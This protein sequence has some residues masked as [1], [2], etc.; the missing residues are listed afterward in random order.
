MGTIAFQVGLG[1]DGQTQFDIF[2]ISQQNIS[3]GDM[4]TKLSSGTILGQF[5]AASLF[6]NSL[7]GLYVPYVHLSFGPTT[8]YKASAGYSM[9]QLTLEVDLATDVPI[10]SGNPFVTLEGLSLEI[11]YGGA[12]DGLPSDISVFGS[13]IVNLG[14]YDADCTFQVDHTGDEIAAFLDDDS[15]DTTGPTSSDSTGGFQGTIMLTID[16]PNETPTVGAMVDGLLGEIPDA[17]GLNSLTKNIPTQLLSILDSN[18]F[19]A[20]EFQIQNDATTGNKWQV[21]YF[22]V[23]ARLEGLGDI[24]NLLPGISFDVPVLDVYIT[25][26]SDPV[27]F[28]FILIRNELYLHVSGPKVISSYSRKYNLTPRWCL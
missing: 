18:V 19:E 1:P 25:Y 24:L 11:I 28:N 7:A 4:L 16:F 9:Q 22:H 27:C 10:P 23:Q 5:E 20:V 8:P 12:A 2:A 15:T 13:A 14:G 21:V 3:V 6:T 17:S 26:P